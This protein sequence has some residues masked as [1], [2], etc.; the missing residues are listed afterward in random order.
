MNVKH[1]GALVRLK[2]AFHD[3]ANLI[4]SADAGITFIS[5]VI[6]SGIVMIN[7]YRVLKVADTGSGIS[8]AFYRIDASCYKRAGIRE[9]E[10]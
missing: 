4:T 2:G 1:K 5:L 8:A 3:A 9:D 6:I 10:D 7:V